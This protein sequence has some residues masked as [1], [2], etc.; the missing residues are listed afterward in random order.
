MS[1]LERW[2][3]RK[4]GLDADPTT[5]GTTSPAPPPVESSPADPPRVEEPADSE[6]PPPLDDTLPD[7]ESLP[8]GSDFSRYLQEGVSQV[9]RRRAL[10]RLW[11]SDHYQVRDGLDD[12]DGDYSQ[13]ET[14]GREVAE[15]LRHW[16]RR[17]GDALEADADD[18]ENPT[19]PVEERVASAAEPPADD[20]AVDAPDEG[21]RGIEGRVEGD[22]SGIQ[23]ISDNRYK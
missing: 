16:S 1:R 13:L 19:V 22:H 14:M 5:T 2:S 6:P 9:L 8:P 21:D 11:Q 23:N 7:P 10:R 4:R 12:Y 18:A 20:P 15:G 3:R 17:V